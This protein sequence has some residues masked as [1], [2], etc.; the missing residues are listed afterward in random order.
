MSEK[1]RADGE[2][3]GYEFYVNEYWKFCVPALERDYDDYTT[4]KD[5]I[6]RAIKAQAATARRKPLAIPA[7]TRDG[8]RV[9]ITGVHAGHGNVIT[10][11][12]IS[13]YGNGLVPDVPWLAEAI[14]EL[15][16][17]RKRERHIIA[18]LDRFKIDT[19]AGY[20]FRLEQYAEQVAKVE[21]SAAA[22]LKSAETT[23]FEKAM[24]ATPIPKKVQF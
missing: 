19:D 9:V 10:K 18:M 3:S 16:R 6:D 15:E 22:V 17:V 1:N 2:Y 5:A 23:N 12:I 7:I 4:M 8:K 20:S 24:Q 11:P 13:R 14:A 21:A